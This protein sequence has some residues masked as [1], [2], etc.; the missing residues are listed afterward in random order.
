MEQIVT[1]APH[2]QQE[3]NLPLSNSDPTTH[4]TLTTRVTSVD[5][6]VVYYDRQV[7]WNR[8]KETDAL[9]YRHGR[10]AAVRSISN[11][12][13]IPAKIS[14]ASSPI[15]A[16][17]RRATKLTTLTATIQRAA[18]A[19]RPQAGNFP[20]HAF[21]NGKQELRFALPPLDGYYQIVLQG[22]DAKGSTAAGGQRFRAQAFP[23]GRLA[24]RAQYHR[25]SAL[26]AH[27]GEREHSLHRAARASVE[28]SRPARP[29]HRDL[30]QYRR[31]QT[32]PRRAHALHGDG[33][34]RRRA[35]H[36]RAA[37]R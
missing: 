19:K 27:H 3:V 11:S 14:C 7:N 6:T 30:R 24:D 2:A 22:Q 9:G 31:G 15:S 18:G 21:N 10:R 13:I 8:A 4:Y 34:R 32:D 17:C 37:A 35:D 26:H 5:G 25:L 33:G 1:L 20:L 28:R 16:I 29:D 12:P 23:V 36:R